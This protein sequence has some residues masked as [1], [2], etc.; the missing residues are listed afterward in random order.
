[1]VVLGGGI[2]AVVLHILREVET[3]GGTGGILKGYSLLGG[4]YS[5][6]VLLHTE[7][8]GDHGYSITE[9]MGGGWVGTPQLELWLGREGGGDH[10]ED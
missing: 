10:D 6:G 8:G 4:V 1:M 2:G 5:I 9:T 3:M 7:G